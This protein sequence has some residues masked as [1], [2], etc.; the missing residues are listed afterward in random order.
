MF[1]SNRLAALTKVISSCWY[2]FRRYFEIKVD[3]TCLM[4]C[5]G[6]TVEEEDVRVIVLA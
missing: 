6:F 4:S 5:F 1:S 2:Y 3:S